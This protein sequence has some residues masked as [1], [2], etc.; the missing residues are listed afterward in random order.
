MTRTERL[1]AMAGQYA[2]ITGGSSS[3]LYLSRPGDGQERWVFTDRVTFTGRTA[4]RHMERLLDD[5]RRARMVELEQ[6]H[7]KATAEYDAIV[8]RAAR[9]AETDEE[10]RAGRERLEELGEEIYE[11][12]V[13]LGIEVAA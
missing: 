8:M 2:A 3:W 7:A 12:E 5:A 13:R 1:A 9:L 10:H 4:L 6:R 11:L